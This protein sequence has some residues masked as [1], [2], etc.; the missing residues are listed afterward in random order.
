M[1]RTPSKRPPVTTN[2]SSS[3]DEKSNS[4]GSSKSDSHLRVDTAATSANSRRPR[5]LKAALD[6]VSSSR[7]PE[8]GSEEDYDALKPD[9]SAIAV[10]GKGGGYEGKDT[11][12]S[13]CNFDITSNNYHT[14]TD[15]FI[16][17]KI[18]SQQNARADLVTLPSRDHLPHLMV[19]TPQL[20]KVPF[21]ASSI[22]SGSVSQF[23]CYNYSLRIGRIME[24][25][26]VAMKLCKL[27]FGGMLLFCYSQAPLCVSPFSLE[28]SYRRLF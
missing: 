1:G 25:F 12:P 24:V 2:T 9:P 22:F 28:C 19:V 20:Q 11:K 3:L 5:S 27:H 13:V 26:L 8:S 18:K 14:I 15:N 4:I 7:T 16:R 23:L 6:S 17:I 21:V 10:G